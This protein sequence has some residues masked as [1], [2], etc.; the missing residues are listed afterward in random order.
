MQMT[1]LRISQMFLLHLLDGFHD[2]L[3][4]PRLILIQLPS[5]DSRRINQL[6][7][8]VV[9]GFRR[10]FHERKLRRVHNGQSLGTQ[11][12]ISL[13]LCSFVFVVYYRYRIQSRRVTGIEP[14]LSCDCRNSSGNQ[15]I[16]EIDCGSFDSDLQWW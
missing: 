9:V 4:A 2:F 14:P 12:K 11:D 16:I 13:D 8:S 7:K 5:S 10:H 1:A 15:P 6:V 3:P